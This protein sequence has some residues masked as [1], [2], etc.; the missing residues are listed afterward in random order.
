[1][2][3]SPALRITDR[4]TGYYA[5]LD[6][7]LSKDEIETCDRFL[8]Q[9]E[10]LFASGPIQNGVDCE[11]TIH[12]TDGKA[13]VETN[14]PTADELDILFQRLRLFVLQ[15]E[16]TS[17]D[18]VCTLVRERLPYPPILQ[19]LKD[20]H[21]AFHNNTKFIPWRLVVND[22]DIGPEQMLNDWIYGYQYHGDDRRRDRLRRAGIDVNSPTIRHKLVWLLLN[23]HVPIRNLASVVAVVRGLNPAFDMG[24]VRLTLS[25][26]E[27]STHA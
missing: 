6:V 26:P 18:N 8:K 12:V 17:F 20:Q 5:L 11:L 24:D 10:D 21:A 14:L 7:D 16:R 9:Y 25:L 1:M 19:F 4:S 3:A 23:K 13:E 2:I 15:E 27:Q 22:S